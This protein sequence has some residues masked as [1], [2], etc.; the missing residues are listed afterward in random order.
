MDEFEQFGG[1][2]L[3]PSNNNDSNQDEFSQFG[4]Y[5]IL[6][7][8]DPTIGNRIAS[9]GKAIVAGA[10]GAIPDNVA[11]AYNLPVM[12]INK[13]RDIAY[14]ERKKDFPLIP[15]ATEAIDRSI[16][17]ATG[18][19]TNT[20]E[21]QKH[22]NEALKFG[23]SMPVGGFIGRSGNKVVSTVG[24]FTGSTD[25][26][27]IAGATAAGGT[28]SYL[29]D[30]G[31][32]TG[33][34]LGG[35]LAA[36]VGVNAIPALTKGGGNLL[37]K[38]L[39][40]ATGLGKGKLNLDAAK[41]AQELDIALPK[42]A[43]SN[44][45]LIALADQILSKAPISGNIMQK[46]Y[47][48]MANKVIK[49]LDDAYDSILPKSEL[50]SVDDKIKQLYDHA[51]EVLPEGAS[52]V[53]K[54]VTNLTEQIK[55]ELSKSASLSP[56]E[57]KVLSVIQDYENKFVPM[58]IKRIPSPV[59]DLVASQDSLGKVIDWKDTSVHSRI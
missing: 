58:G 52:V 51:K 19:Y 38:G 13:L 12:G 50:A 5:S 7:Q 34:T 26:A 27:Q 49:E 18:G 56:G 57:K 14:P 28:M 44:G 4:G 3:N 32:T 36:N 37:A 20:P 1:Y 10:G 48:N 16:D 46:R 53:P 2:Q 17:S 25:K 15:S 8:Q 33:E 40:T 11:L 30:Q 31:A 47:L 43:A 35:G 55:T 23:A 21:D 6:D 29:H 24:K 22:I 59:G 42:A 9:G 54:N 39:I 45:K 41:A